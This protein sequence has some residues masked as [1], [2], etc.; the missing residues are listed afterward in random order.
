MSRPTGS[1][2][3]Y[4]F[5]QMIAEVIDRVTDRAVLKPGG[6]SST[7]KGFRDCST[8]F[9]NDWVTGRRSVPLTAKAAPD[10]SNQARAFLGG[11]LT[12][13]DTSARNIAGVFGSAN[14]SSIVCRSDG[15]MNTESSAKRTSFALSAMT[16]NCPGNQN[17]LS[18]KEGSATALTS[19]KFGRL[20]I[21]LCHSESA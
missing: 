11:E 9:N 2:Q 14:L 16:E 19:R 12:S 18:S 5:D 3:A 17:K 8:T 21:Q 10:Y 13:C 6:S 7:L 15:P 4:K 20:L 1:L